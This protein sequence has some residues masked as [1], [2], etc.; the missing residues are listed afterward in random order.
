MGLLDFFRRKG[1]TAR[2][3]SETTAG[4]A[5]SPPDDRAHGVGVPPGS[6]AEGPPVGVSDPG[7][8]TGEDA[9]EV[10]ASEEDVELGGGDST[11]PT[12]A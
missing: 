8:L 10:V 1:A 3:S 4:G 2:G 7:S 9:G 5:A 12:G 11:R 6:A